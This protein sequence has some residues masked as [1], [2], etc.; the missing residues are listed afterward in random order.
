MLDFGKFLR[1]SVLIALAARSLGRA[2]YRVH[3]DLG[4]TGVVGVLRSGD[5]PTVLL[6][7]DMDALPVHED[8]GLP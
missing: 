2:G 6:P 5:G 1:W 3:T 4:G 8:T 7:A